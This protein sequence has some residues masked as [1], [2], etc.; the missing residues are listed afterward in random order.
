MGS[1]GDLLASTT[2]EP[3]CPACGYPLRVSLLEVAAQV[4]RYCPAC[5]RL[6]RM[7]DHSGTVSSGATSAASAVSRLERQFEGFS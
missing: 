5:Y 6:V 4:S 3:P 1:F 7:V 2:L